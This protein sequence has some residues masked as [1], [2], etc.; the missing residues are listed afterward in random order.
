MSPWLPLQSRGFRYTE[1]IKHGLC[2]NH[3]DA[4]SAKQFC[5]GCDP[6]TIYEPIKP[7][8]RCQHPEADIRYAERQTSAC[9]FDL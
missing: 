2:R 7:R 5:C 4:N 8:G 3:P 1:E 6:S 9:E